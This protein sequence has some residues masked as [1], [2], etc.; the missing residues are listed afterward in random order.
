LVTIK[1]FTSYL[2]EDIENQDKEAQG[3]DIGY[4]QNAADKMGDLLNELLELSRIGRKDNPKIKL[5]LQT[6]VAS[7][8]DLVAGQIKE[9]GVEIIVTD[10]PVMLVCDRQRIV[11]L[12]QNLIDNAVKFMGSQQTPKVEIGA[13]YDKKAEDKIIFFV[14]DN[15]L[16]IDPRYH[17][18]LFGLFEKLDTNTGGTGIGLALVK[19]IVEVHNGKVWF[20]SEGICK[21]TTFYFTISNSTISNP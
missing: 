18:K 15:G 14:R 4:I 3:K 5:S 16:G 8:L 6:L 12:F 13:K 2:V 9:R 17:H 11:Q 10:L 19:R 21:G 20:E 1:S 7:A